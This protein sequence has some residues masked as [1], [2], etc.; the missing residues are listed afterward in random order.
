MNGFLRK[1]VALAV[2]L[3]VSGC[4]AV[5]RFGSEG[6]VTE[7]SAAGFAADTAAAAPAPM[8]KA[9]RS[10]NQSDAVPERKIVYRADLTIETTDLVGTREKI[11]NL[12]E[13]EN[14]ILE[15]NEQNE[16]Q[17]YLSLKIPAEKF[18]EFLNEA[19]AVGRVIYSSISANDVTEQYIDTE[20][21]LASKRALLE[22]YQSYLPQAKDLKEILEVEA[23]I[24]SVTTELEQWE[25]RL[26]RLE[27]EVAYSSVSVRLKLPTYVEKEDDAKTIADLFLSIGKNL[28]IAFAY[29]ALGLI[30]IA[31]VGG[32][33]IAAVVIIALCIRIVRRKK[34]GKTKA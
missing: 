18:E 29:I 33:F 9:M 26:Q 21:R 34:R 4:S 7:E 27:K 10:A 11:L 8:M 20:T 23:Q 31:A 14:G 25:G 1:T 30:Y 17:F 16:Q 22:K 6:G 2:I 19:K 12:M 3:T 24:N 13:T 5:G 32:P 15:Y 28:R